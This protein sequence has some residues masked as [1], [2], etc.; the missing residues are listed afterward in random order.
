MLVQ[1][2]EGAEVDHAATVAPNQAQRVS[3]ITS[4]SAFPDELLRRT[5][6]AL[7]DTLSLFLLATLL[8][9]NHYCVL[10]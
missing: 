7:P 5:S 10:E 9:S 1:A 2:A 4:N 8:G 3:R 6:D